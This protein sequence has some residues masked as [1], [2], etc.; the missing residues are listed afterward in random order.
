LSASLRK[1]YVT[2]ARWAGIL[3]SDRFRFVYRSNS[4]D[5]RMK[6]TMKLRVNFVVLDTG[7]NPLQIRKPRQM[8]F[9]TCFFSIR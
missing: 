8:L 4:Y 2:S 6:E 5:P 3:D 7:D 9:C 1:N